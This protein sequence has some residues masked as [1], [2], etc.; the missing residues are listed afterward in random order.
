M[1]MLEGLHPYL[2]SGGYQRTSPCTDTYNC[3]AFAAGDL[4]RWWE[5]TK[6]PP[7]FWPIVQHDYKIPSFIIA[8][9]I[10]GFTVCDS[11]ALEPGLEKIAVFVDAEDDISH[12]ALQEVDGTWKSKCGDLFDIAHSLNDLNYGRLALYMKRARVTRRLPIFLST[13][14][15]QYHLVLKSQGAQD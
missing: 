12:A 9:Q 7:Y 3:F 15:C 13:S 11:D 2:A 5:P 8:F 1:K 6:L 14:V 4:T 10:I